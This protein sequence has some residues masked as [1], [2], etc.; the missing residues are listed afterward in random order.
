MD[1][2]ETD[3]TTTAYRIF[4]GKRLGGPRRRRDGNVK[5]ERSEVLMAVK[6]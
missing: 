4:V 5:N 1:V 3:D 6:T 2:T